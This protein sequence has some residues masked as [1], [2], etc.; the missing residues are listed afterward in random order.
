[1]RVTQKMLFSRYVTNL[2]KSLTSLM[3][4]NIK[5]QTQKRINKPSDD[6]T[7]MT[8]ILDHRD[9][10]RSLDQYSENISTAKGWLTSADESLMQVSTILTRAKEL[11]T[12]AATG[13]VDS[14]NREQISY[15]L[16]S[17]FEQLV[18]LAN[19]NFEGKQI[20]GGHKVNTPAF[21]EIMWLTTNDD[22]FGNNAEFT[23][24]GSS[25]STVLVQ[26]FDSSG[27]VAPGGNM[28]LSD[29]NLGVRYS[30][31]GGDTWQT[32]GSVTFAAGEGTLSLPQSGT[33]VTF[34]NDTAIKVNDP[35]DESVADGTWLW[36]RPSAQYMGDDEDAPPSVDPLGPGSNLIDATASGSFL[37]TNVTVRIDNSSAVAMNEDIEYSY[38]IDG[39]INW[40]T[41]NIA[42]ADTSSNAAV[43]SVAN[44]GILSLASNGSNL[45]QPGQ[46]FVIRPRSAAINLDVSSSE[47]VQVNGVG[48][49]IFG[50]IY[51]D[52]E[53]VL[54]SNGSILTL[55]SQNSGRV[56]HSNAAPGMAISIQGNDEYSKNLFEVMGNLVAMA[57][58]NNQT[59]VQQ[60]LANLS[61]AQEHIMNAVAEVGGRE[62]RLQIGE[63]IVDGLK[64]NEQTLVSSIEDADV[65]ELMTELAQQQI[66]YE[67]VL[68]S[69]SMI[70]QLNLGKFI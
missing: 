42:Q 62:N 7:G 45:L 39:G 65:S 8:R 2:N 32:D 37:D 15:E 19:T 33:S 23:V 36:I 6:P 5:A 11:A 53:I 55:S 3:D 27:T 38:S 9:T 59:G 70:M 18:G 14:N 28:N 31:D 12:Q 13:T 43:L 16:R 26:F 25:N 21:K 1:M 58:T 10:L 67:S 63:T 17:L 29:G 68:R 44:G 41:G 34:H 20:Y 60:A 66:V 54:A 51:M 61:E 24:N 69:T 46:Q 57:E 49:D 22:S 30:I 52:P 64:L 35:A 56:F 48:K 47:Q 50:G 4:L 40:V